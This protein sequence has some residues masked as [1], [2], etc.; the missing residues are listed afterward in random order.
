MTNPKPP[1]NTDGSSA[2]QQGYKRTEVGII[3]EDWDH[4]RIGD[5]AKVKGGKRLPSS[6]ALVDIPTPHPYLRVVDMRPG[7]VDQSA[8]K[9]VP[10]EAYP[11]IQRYRIFSD[12][13]FISVAGTLGIV[14][15]VP[16]E[17]SGASLT[18]NADR[19]TDIRCARDYLK[20]WLMSQPIQRAI[21]S[22][23]TVGAQP[24]LA[25]GRI[26]RFDIAIP[27]DATEQS[28]IAEALSDVD[29]LLG[30]LETLV[31]KKRAIKQGAMQE[32]LTGKTR[33][34]GFC[35]EW[36]TRQLGDLGRFLKGSGV[37]RDNAQSGPLA[38]VRY[39]EIYTTHH[40]YVRSFHSWISAEIAASATRLERG[41]LLFA[42]S[43]ETK[44]EI[45]KCVAFLESREAYAGGD[46]VILRPRGVDSLF[47]G[48][49]LNTFEVNRQKAS[50]GQGDA[51][52]H[53]SATA[54]AQV[55]LQ[56]PPAE[57]QSAIAKVL[58]DMDDEIDALE[59]WQGKTRAIKG[60]MM[61]QLLIGRVRL[62]K[63]RAVS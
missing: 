59:R 52:V 25:L 24:K 12:D 22:I 54:L 4:I 61:Q 56:M 1:R 3:P 40:D 2:L 6:Y 9:Y 53:I 51:V 46:I 55:C 50:R 28:A 60:G 37:T 41:D 43:G 39:G 7:G 33:L 44:E 15:V 27:R 11:S 29:E 63:L 31:A 36:E 58:S 10:E 18:E 13:I 38:C 45:G 35:A 57:E 42:G 21:E 8:I 49:S 16:P 34:P 48:Y 26:A 17:L 20:Y 5:V 47:L 23:R 62:V 30:A 19:I 32:L 14:G